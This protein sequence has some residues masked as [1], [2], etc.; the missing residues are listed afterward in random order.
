[1]YYTQILT[2]AQLKTI[3]VTQMPNASTMMDPFCANATIGTLET[4]Q[5]VK[6][7]EHISM[8]TLIY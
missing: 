3:T 8:Q 1:M 6:V 5:R 2:S 4:E 7:C